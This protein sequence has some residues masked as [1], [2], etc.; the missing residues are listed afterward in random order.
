M[1][2]P[3]LIIEVASLGEENRDGN[4]RYKAE[5]KIHQILLA[6]RCISLPMMQL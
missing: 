4:Y 2:P 3:I 5:L 6:P 1:P